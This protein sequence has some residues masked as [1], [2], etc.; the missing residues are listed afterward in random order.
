MNTTA[1][2]TAITAFDKA[3]K[4]DPNQEIWE[5]NP[6]PKE[7]LYAQRMS[8]CLAKFEPTAS[9]ALRLAAHSQHICRWEIPRKS[10][11]MDR[12]GYHNWRNTLKKFHAE[13]VATILTPLGYSTDTITAV[14]GLLMKRKL[15]SNP[16]TQALEDVICLVFLEYYLSDFTTHY[17]E[18]KLIGILQKTWRKMSDKGHSFAL[19]IP[20][21]NEIQDLIGKA[22][23]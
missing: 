21:S 1:F 17:S 18:E 15:K 9:E 2:Q 12:Q 11:P 6:Y 10:F 16:D 3:N 20:F 14:K 5:G 23:A 8:A 19:K 13:K 4:A 7:W 22:L